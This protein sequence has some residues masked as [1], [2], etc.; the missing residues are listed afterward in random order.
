MKIRGETDRHG[1][2][3]WCIFTTFRFE[4]PKKEP[5][6]GSLHGDG[7]V[8]V[9]LMEY[10]DSLHLMCLHVNLNLHNGTCAACRNLGLPIICIA[11]LKL[12][13]GVP[14]F[15]TTCL[16]YLGT[17]FVREAISR[18]TNILKH[19]VVTVHRVNTLSILINSSTVFRYKTHFVD[20]HSLLYFKLYH[21]KVVF[22]K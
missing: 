5:G 9:P 17:Y 15:L 22:V 1:K 7:P 13:L 19:T 14:R 12:H 6:I 10:K 8:V 18:L 4:R 21:S 2:A 3:N 16:L 11:L 20:C